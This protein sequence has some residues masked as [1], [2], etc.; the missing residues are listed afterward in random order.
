VAFYA[1]GDGGRT[2]RL[3][4][5]RTVQFPVLRLTSPFV[6]YVPTSVVGA[7]TWWVAEGRTTPVL[8]VTHDAGR[9]WQTFRPSELP[10]A[11]WWEISAVGRRLA[12]LTT[13][14][15]GTLAG[16]IWATEDSGRKWRPLAR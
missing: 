8:S 15:P 16:R 1:T 3:R 12:W 5:V 7:K 14:A 9:T 4:A 6:W 11:S 2:W 13:Y 10:R